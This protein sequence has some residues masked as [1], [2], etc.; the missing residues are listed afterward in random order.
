VAQNAAWRPFGERY[1]SRTLPNPKS[2]S[3]QPQGRDTINPWTGKAVDPHA[4]R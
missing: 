1:L 3:N 4:G 2:R